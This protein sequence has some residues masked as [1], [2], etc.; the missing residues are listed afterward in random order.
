MCGKEIL[1]DALRERTLKDGALHRLEEGLIMAFLNK[2]MAI[3]NL[4][5]EPLVAGIDSAVGALEM[6]T[7][8]YQSALQRAVVEFP[9]KDRRHPLCGAKS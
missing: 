6:I 5:K 2:V 9:L 7:G 3:G 8:A 4:G 1:H